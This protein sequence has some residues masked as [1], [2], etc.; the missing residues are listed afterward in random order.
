MRDLTGDWRQCP[1]P[2]HDLESSNVNGFAS[3][4]KLKYLSLRGSGFA[5][6]ML[7]FVDLSSVPEFAMVT[8]PTRGRHVLNS[9]F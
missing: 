2:A 8:I 3:A 7:P 9:L 6:Q 1:D 4:T 5:T